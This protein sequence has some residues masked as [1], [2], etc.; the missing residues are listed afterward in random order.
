[1]KTTQEKMITKALITQG[2]V[3]RNR[4]LRG[5]YGQFITR[6][7]AVMCDLGKNGWSFTSGYE[8][9]NGGKDYVYRLS[10]DRQ[11]LRVRSIY[12]GDVKVSEVIERT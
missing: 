8:K 3:S 7:G 6:L 11:P 10:G 12:V 1:M 9:T 2:Y 4:A 5:E